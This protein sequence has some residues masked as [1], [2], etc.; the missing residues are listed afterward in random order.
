M[1]SKR[2]LAGLGAIGILGLLGFL[3]ALLSWW[4][5]VVLAVAGMLGVLGVIAL[6]TNTLVRSHRLAW[7]RTQRLGGGA[8][9]ASL[10]TGPVSAPASQDDLTGALRLLQ[11]QYVG[12]LDRAQTTLDRAAAR[13]DRATGAAA[14]TPPPADP[15]DALPAGAVL[16]LH[17][18]TEASIERARRATARGLGVVVVDPDSA[19]RERLELAGLAGAVR[20]VGAGEAPAGAVSVVLPD[21]GT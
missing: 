16:T 21:A 4:W 19:D 20:V 7:D 8:A 10:I 9:G 14:P 2:V 17:A 15:I 1:T 3:G 12:R 6:N 13:L 11:A 5:L 18:V